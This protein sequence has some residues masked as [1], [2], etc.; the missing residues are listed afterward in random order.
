DGVTPGPNQDGLLL[1]AGANNNRVGGPNPGDGNVIARNIADAIF[2]ASNA[3]A[4]TA[5]GNELRQNGADG[6]GISGAG[7]TADSN[8]VRDNRIH[9][10]G[11]FGV[12]IFTETGGNKNN[13]VANNDIYN[14]AND[15]IQILSS[16]AT[17]NRITQNRIYNNGSTAKHL[18]ID[19]DTDG[20]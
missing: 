1:F 10:N 15:G 7:G 20:V 2:I 8:V 19:L 6:I 4:N 16:S 12:G 5:Q 3:D 18:G 13:L 9:D 17:G 11:R 14:N